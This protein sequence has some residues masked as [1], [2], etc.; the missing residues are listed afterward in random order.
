MQASNTRMMIFPVAHLVSYISR[1][2]TLEPGDVILTGTPS[3]VALGRDPPRY[4]RAGDE[5]QL[6]ISGLGEQRQ[7]VLAAE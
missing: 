6:S 5:L 2:M 1:F 4:L 3:G 7:L